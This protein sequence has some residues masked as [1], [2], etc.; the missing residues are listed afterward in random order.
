MATAGDW[1]CST[2]GVSMKLAVILAAAG[3]SRRFGVDKLAQ[4]LGGRPLLVRT[5]EAFTRRDE[6]TQIIVAGPPDR[7]DEFH[8]RFGPTLGFHG[9]ELVQGGRAERWETIAASLAHLADEVTHVAVHDAARPCVGEALL[10]RL[11][12]AAATVDAVV[13]G[14]PVTSTLK[15]AGKPRDVATQDVLVDSILGDDTAPQLDVRQIEDT[16]SREGLFEI[17]TPQVFSRQAILSAYESVDPAGSTDDA[18]VL[19][20][21]GLD[22]HVVEGDATN[23]KITRPADLRLAAAMIKSGLIA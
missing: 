2:D 18:S 5:V 22:V 7:W 17:Q 20:K 8:A 9:A 21:A 6:V 15:R 14:I 12:E 10:D 11:I 3:S 4:D 23:I 1:A 19:E 13:P 16:V